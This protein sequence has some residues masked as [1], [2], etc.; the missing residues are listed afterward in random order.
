MKP[1]KAKMYK[2]NLQKAKMKAGKAKM[3]G[4]EAKKAPRHP[5]KPLNLGGRVGFG[6][7]GLGYL[8]SKGKAPSGAGCRTCT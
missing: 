1:Q 2:L 5:S 3:K 7:W 8:P 6:G 4:N